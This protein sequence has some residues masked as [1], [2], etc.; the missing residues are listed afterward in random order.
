MTEHSYGSGYYALLR[1]AAGATWQDY[2]GHEFVRGLGDGSLPKQAFLNYLKQDYVFLLHFSRAWALGVV[3]SGSLD[4]MKTCA[5][6]VDALVNHEIQLHVQV[7][8][9]EGISE[10]E[11]LETREEFENIAYTRF[12]IEAGL[13]G[14]FLDLV[15]ALAPCVFG[16]GEIGKRLQADHNASTPYKEWISTYAGDDYQEVCSTVA[17]MLENAVT[18]RLGPDAQDLPRWSAL[19][20]RFRRATELEV[21]FW[22]MGLRLGKLGL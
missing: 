18:A 9:A 5:A 8:A 6:T 15:A 19:S 2:V 12:V 17:L 7:C 3:K 16:Y 4:E 14:D 22:D 1:E 13:S 21:G 10:N 11:L 20:E